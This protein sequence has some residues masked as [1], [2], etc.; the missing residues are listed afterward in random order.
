M[1]DKDEHNVE[2]LF[3]SKLYDFEVDTEPEDWEAI[4]NR[5]SDS[6]VVPFRNRLYYWAAAAAVLLLMVTGGVYWSTREVIPST[7]VEEIKDLNELA[8]PE[9]V[10][11]K[12]PIAVVSAEQ[13][14]QEP[15]SLKARIGMRRVAMAQGVMPIE[16]TVVAEAAEAEIIEEP[17]QEMSMAVNAQDRSAEV[18]DVYQ[19]T[20]SVR[21]SV[22]QEKPRKR[23]WGFGMGAGSL[24][25]GADNMVP[26]Y[27]MNSTSLRS[28]SLMLMNAPYFNKELPKTDIRHKTPV[29]FGLSA[30]RYLTDRLSLQL[31]L[32]YSFLQSEWTTNG[33]YY[34]RTK[35]K[36]HFIGL[37]VSLSYKLA[38]WNRFV[39]YLSAG[40]MTEVN[41]AGSLSSRIYNDNNQEITCRNNHVR[42]KEWLW[43][44]NT[45]TGVSYPVWRFVNAFA[46]V[47]ASYYFDNGSHIET[48]H[49]EK[50][51]NVSLQLGFRLGF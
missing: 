45:A 5:L 40:A 14:K 7:V 27:V 43:S 4:A 35:Q 26:S 10:P 48:I 23:K 22:Y 32:N 31:G 18:T 36:L 9:T 19:E 38:E 16:K 17:E 50:P 28:E 29:S 46:E 8:K 49:S 41:V 12:D 25:M 44:V 37:P 47:G 20:Q 1:K 51:F 15:R 3:R 11:V 30:S 6:N 34:G 24:S 42:M 39:F 21:Q 33:D 2:E 13:E